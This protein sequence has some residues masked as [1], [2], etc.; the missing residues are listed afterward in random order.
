MRIPSLKISRVIFAIN[1]I[2][3]VESI[4]LKFFSLLPQIFF[5]T[6]YSCRKTNDILL[7]VIVSGKTN[8]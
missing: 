8:I 3:S 6:C 4:V 2:I 1:E 7:F 5:C